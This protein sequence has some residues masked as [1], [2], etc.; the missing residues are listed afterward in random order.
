MAADKTANTPAT[1]AGSSNNSATSG[2]LSGGDA[3]R[4]LQFPQPSELSAA[5]T[6]LPS[7]FPPPNAMM[8]EQ[9]MM[10]A[11]TFANPLQLQ[12]LP[13]L[14][15]NTTNLQLVLS[16]ASAGGMQHPAPPMAQSSFAPSSTV[17]GGM[18]HSAPLMA[19]SPFAPPTMAQSSFAPPPSSAMQQ[20]SASFRAQMFPSPTRC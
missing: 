7:A 9:T 20:P 12:F 15:L 8:Q 14:S 13:N 19:Q 4:V 16:N 10:A 18:P 2:P 5:S 17:Q 6:M 11:N 1:L 3:S